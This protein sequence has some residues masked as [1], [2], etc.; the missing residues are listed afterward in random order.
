M[1]DVV[2]DLREL[3]DELALEAKLERSIRP[4]SNI[5]NQPTLIAEGGITQEAGHQTKSAA[6]A[7]TT[8]SAEYIVSEIKQHKRGIAVASLILLIAAIGASYWFF[9][10]RSATAKPI[11]SIAVMPFVNESGNQD[12][13][14]L[15][16][17][18]TETLIKS[19]SNLPNLNVKPRS[20]V[21]RYKGK[22]TD[23]RRSAKS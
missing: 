6:V 19:L 21:F 18:M 3:R 4:L 16:D 8:S 15:S 17:G 23:Y 22:D 12:F 5:G 14:Y 2:L 11:E 20:S 10:L 13:E 7:P 1:K 9:S